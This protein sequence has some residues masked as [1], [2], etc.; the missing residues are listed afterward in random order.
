M[1]GSDT[2][3]SPKKPRH[4]ESNWQASYSKYHLKASKKGVTYAH[5][6]VCNYDFSVAG[7]RVHEVKC[8]CNSVKHIELLRISR[9][10]H[11]SLLI[12]AHVGAK[13]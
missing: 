12:F 3:S 7:G 5:C 9:D 2:G 6:T 4:L 11:P 1:S 13:V 10:N 8:H